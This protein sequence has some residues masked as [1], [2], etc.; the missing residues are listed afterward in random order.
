MMIRIKRYLA[1]IFLII[2]GAV[3]FSNSL[4]GKPDLIKPVVSITG[5]ISDKITGKAVA[6]KIYIYKEEGKK[7]GIVKS[8]ILDGSFFITG[9]KPAE[10]YILSLE[11]KGYINRKIEIAT[12]AVSEYEEIE[13]DFYVYPDDDEVLSRK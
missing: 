7:I 2:A 13:R 12:P 8:N 10:K 5:T 11:A 3:I 4:I 9:L 6:I 1:I